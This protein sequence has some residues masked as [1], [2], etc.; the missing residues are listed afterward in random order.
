MLA[1]LLVLVR[2]LFSALLGGSVSS[3]M[4]FAVFVLIPSPPP[5]FLTK[6]QRRQGFVGERTRE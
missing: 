3:W 1:A 4:L 6:V 2:R 5:L